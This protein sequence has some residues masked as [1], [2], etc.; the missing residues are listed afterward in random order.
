MFENKR[1]C[2]CDKIF[3]LEVTYSGF[4]FAVQLDHRL[5]ITNQNQYMRYE[6]R[7]EFIHHLF[8]DRGLLYILAFS[9]SCRAFRP[10]MSVAFAGQPILIPSSSFG[11]GI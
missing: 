5:K 10:S 9:S 1:E 7:V 11:L 3:C 6:S 4:D 2:Q 8:C